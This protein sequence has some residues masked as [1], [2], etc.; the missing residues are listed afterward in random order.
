M[1]VADSVAV[2]PKYNVVAPARDKP[3]DFYDLIHGRKLTQQLVE[4]IE[5][6]GADP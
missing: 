3:G 5:A 1:A 4:V 6:E 2:L